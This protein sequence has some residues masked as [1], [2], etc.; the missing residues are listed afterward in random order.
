M[1]VPFLLWLPILVLT[2]TVAGQAATTVNLSPTSGHP[3]T[4]VTVS[5]TSF[6]DNEAVDV[7]VDTVDTLLLVASS[8]GSISGSITIPASAAPG[9]HDITAIGRHSGDA[10]QTTFDVG[11]PWSQFG[12]SAAHTSA[13]PWENAL[14]PSNVASI[15]PKWINPGGSLGSTGATVAVNFGTIYASTETGIEALSSSTGGVLWSYTA[16]G[17]V[18]ASPTLSAGV[19][20]VGSESTDT[21]YALNATTGAK[22][23]SVVLGGAIYSSAAIANGIVYVGC[24]DDKVHALNASTGKAI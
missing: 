5:G 22:I 10:A 6:G 12:Y 11:S 18:F 16:A 4:V 13:N 19:V 9:T 8:T 17:T 15:G 23:W 21:L 24:D 14:S 7:Y 2:T 3:S 1:R 20:Y